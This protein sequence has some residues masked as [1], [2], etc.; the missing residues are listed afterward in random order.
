MT[1][2]LKTALAAY[3]VSYLRC[4]NYCKQLDICG[5]ITLVFFK[6][7]MIVMEGKIDIDVSFAMLAIATASTSNCKP[8]GH[9]C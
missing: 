2:I 4:H 7:A 9:L 5:F 8:L 1:L 3:P 6:L